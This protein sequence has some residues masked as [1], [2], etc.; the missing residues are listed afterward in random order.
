MDVFHLMNHG[1]SGRQTPGRRL[2]DELITALPPGVEWTR[3]E[4]T[5][6]ASVEVMADRL[7]VLRK[8]TDAA[9]AD[10]E[11]PAAQ[12]AVLSN[13]TRCLEVSMNAMVRTLDP[14]MVAQPKSER[15]QRAALSRWHGTG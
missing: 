9:L 14:E 13:A 6:L 7:A 12:V 11:T 4:R 1:R 10:P 15:H 3:I 5:T 8:R 2:I